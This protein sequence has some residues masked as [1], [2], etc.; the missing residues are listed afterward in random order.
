MILLLGTSGALHD[1]ASSTFEHSTT[2]REANFEIRVSS[3]RTTLAGPICFADAS[4]FTG[5]SSNRPT[6]TRTTKSAAS[7][8]PAN[9]GFKTPPFV[10]WTSLYL[11]RHG[12]SR[13][14]TQS[15]AGTSNRSPLQDDDFF[16]P[17]EEC[18][19]WC[20]N[21]SSLVIPTNN[22]YCIKNTE[23]NL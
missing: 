14:E 9:V 15:Q 20:R 4:A 6:S 10:L 22:K 8:S 17:V 13:S 2:D 5:L 21:K 16:D 19:P 7:N 1:W 23:L 12:R 3:H 18:R 11:A